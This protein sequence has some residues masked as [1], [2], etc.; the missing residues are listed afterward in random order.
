MKTVN[1]DTIEVQVSTENPHGVKTE[2][3]NQG[4]K[5]ASIKQVN[6]KRNINIIIIHMKEI[7]IITRNRIKFIVV[8][9]IVREIGVGVEIIEP[10]GGDYLISNNKYFLFFVP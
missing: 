2:V 1:T 3:E 9:I 7:L 5:K 8:I 10:V 4:L 6:L